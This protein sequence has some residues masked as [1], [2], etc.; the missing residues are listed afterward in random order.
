M[1]RFEENNR[2]RSSSMEDML[3]YGYIA[4]SME[5]QQLR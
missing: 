1:N 4:L 5:S 2:K 3:S